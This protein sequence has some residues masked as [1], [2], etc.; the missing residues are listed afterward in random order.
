MPPFAPLLFLIGSGLMPPLPALPPLVPITIP[1]P[2]IEC[3]S[4]SYLAG[5]SAHKMQIAIGIGNLMDLMDPLLGAACD[6]SSGIVTPGAIEEDLLDPWRPLWRL[7][8]A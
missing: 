4:I 1:E 5:G 7:T 2:T 3:A 6:A 8:N